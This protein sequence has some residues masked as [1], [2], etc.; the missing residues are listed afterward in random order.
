MSASDSQPAVSV[1]LPFR[2]AESTLAEALE[3]IRRQSLAQ[4]ECILVDHRS[5]DRSASLAL[6]L[7][8][9]DGRFRVVRGEGSFVAAL[10]RGVEESQSGLIA[11]MD[12]DDV[13]HPER[14]ERQVDALTR[15]PELQL[16]SCR[17]DCFSDTALPAGMKR[18]EKW[19]NSVV[20]GKEIRAAIFVESPLPHP[21]VVFRRRA[22]ERFGRYRETEGPED[23]DL[24]LRMIIGGAVVRK[25]P[26]VL[27][28]WRDTPQ[29]MSRSDRR[30][31]KDRFFDTKLRHFPAA[32][33]ISTPL[34]FW[35][36]GRTARRWARHLRE[37]GY[38]I[39][40]FVDVIEDRVGRTVQGLTVETP[41]AIDRRDG[42]VVAAVGV[43][44]A[45]QIIE[46]DLQQ[47]GFRRGVDYIAVA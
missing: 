39:R 8:S 34:Q 32:V 25:L 47:R 21:S 2:N 37:A 11:R 31:D 5:T 30:Y 38:E 9:E 16:I 3:S 18:Y 4:F 35:G 42:I 26:D 45:R 15:D 24:W 28:R 20:S 10:N 1:V 27:L 36:T 44:G 12:A 29:R 22:F 7:A 41:A 40:R 6:T 43:L 46:N 14:L 23:Y 19:V 33:P 13:C 17:V